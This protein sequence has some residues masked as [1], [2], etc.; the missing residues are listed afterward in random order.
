MLSA[1][2]IEQDDKLRKLNAARAYVLSMIDAETKEGLFGEAWKEFGYCNDVAEKEDILFVDSIWPYIDIAETLEEQHSLLNSDFLL[3]LAIAKRF[4]PQ[5]KEIQHVIKVCIELFVIRRAIARDYVWVQS[6]VPFPSEVISL[7]VNQG[8]QLSDELIYELYIQ[9]NKYAEVI[10]ELFDRHKLKINFEEFIDYALEQR[11]ERSKSDLPAYER[12]QL[13]LKYSH[14]LMQLGAKPEM[15]DPELIFKAFSDLLNASQD[16]LTANEKKKLIE[17]KKSWSMNVLNQKFPLS[18]RT[19]ELIRIFTA[20]DFNQRCENVGYDILVA[21]FASIP[22][23]Q[24]TRD[25]LAELETHEVGLS[26]S[27]KRLPDDKKLDKLHAQINVLLPI[28]QLQ[29]ERFMKSLAD[30]PVTPIKEPTRADIYETIK[31]DIKMKKDLDSHLD[32]LVDHLDEAEEIEIP[33][34]KE[35]IV[36]CANNASDVKRREALENISRFIIEN[37]KSGSL[38]WWIICESA[39]KILILIPTYTYQANYVINL[40]NHLV[41]SSFNHNLDVQNTIQQLLEIKGFREHIDYSREDNDYASLLL[42]NLMNSKN[43]EPEIAMMLVRAGANPNQLDNKGR[44]ILMRLSC[45]NTSTVID[46]EGVLDAEIKELVEVHHADVNLKL[47]NSEVQEK[48]TALEVLLRTKTGHGSIPAIM[49]LIRLGAKVD[50]AEIMAAFLGNGGI[51]RE[52]SI[53]YNVINLVNAGVSPQMFVAKEVLDVLF[54]F[55]KVTENSLAAREYLK[56]A[57]DRNSSLGKVVRPPAIDLNSRF[58]V[59]EAARAN[60]EF[61]ARVYATLDALDH[62]P[63]EKLKHALDD[64]YYWPSVINWSAVLELIKNEGANPNL[65]NLRLI[66]RTLPSLDQFKEMLELGLDVSGP[67]NGLLLDLF[68]LKKYDFIALLIEYGMPTYITQ[69]AN[70]LDC[71]I[72][73]G[74][75]EISPALLL[76]MRSLLNCNVPLKSNILEECALI[77]K[78]L[79]ETAKGEDLTPNILYNLKQYKKLLLAQILSWQPGVAFSALEKIS[80]QPDSALGQVFRIGH[81]DRSRGT[82]GKACDEYEKRKRVK[83][84]KVEPVGLNP[85]LNMMILFCLSKKHAQPGFKFDWDKAIKLIQ[86]NKA[87]PNIE[88]YTYETG[89]PSSKVKF[90]LSDVFMGHPIKPTVE[91]MER[92]LDLGLDKEKSHTISDHKNLLDI[93]VANDLYD[94]ALLF[95]SKGLRSGGST[96]AYRISNYFSH[97]TLLDKITKRLKENPELPLHSYLPRIMQYEVYLLTDPKMSFRVIAE[98]LY[99]TAKPE[100]I[101]DAICANLKPHKEALLTG[102]LSMGIDACVEPL[103]QISEDEHS[104]LGR[105]FR[106]GHTDRSKGTFGK[107]CDVYEKRNKPGTKLVS[108]VETETPSVSNNPIAWATTL[109]GK[110]TSSAAVSSA[111]ILAAVEVD[112]GEKTKRSPTN[113]YSSEDEKL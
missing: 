76:C 59:D 27:V 53:L 81:T 112:R 82:F 71:V 46:N 64:G 89:D 9:R 32:F 54:A 52:K 40:L 41:I 93:A 61:F 87:N 17:L 90:G 77:A 55:V 45:I 16:G 29:S 51:S 39:I 65:I 109:W 33:E 4:D 101:T 18:M 50:V 42:L 72:V 48:S 5:N 88:A 14:G 43:F 97:T 86:D 36:L 7:L 19:V 79:I 34:I 84:K 104:V 57:R 22:S 85:E 44:S 111:T 96:L 69:D 2:E 26:A 99:K 110:V 1:R 24:I 98:W 67:D 95:L 30:S 15:F 10:K 66:E 105:I 28:R 92:L 107:A 11:K 20:A 3:S 49:L 74:L 8:L 75:R 68:T 78:W 35:L 73:D 25:I 37:E 100:E 6:N 83:S 60:K 70:V 12:A 56:A 47:H 106:T 94:H 63:N 13:I 103:R 58:N 113:G 31:N 38:T 108:F 62:S 91:Q 23:E 80:E 102:I 21:Y